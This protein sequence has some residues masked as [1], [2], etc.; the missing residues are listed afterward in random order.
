MA[1]DFDSLLAASSASALADATT[2]L[3]AGL[4][5]D[6]AAHGEDDDFSEPERQWESLVQWARQHGKELP[7][8]FPGPEREGGREHD[9]RIHE[10][11]GRWIKYTKPASCGYTVSYDDAGVPFMHN[12]V[13]L[14]YLQ[15][16]LWQNELFGDDIHLLGMWQAEPY[17][18]CIVTSQ[19]GLQGER[20]TLDELARAFIAAGFMPLPWRGIGYEG[21]LS[22]RADGF[23]FWDVHPANV[24]I[25]G[26]GLPLAVDVIVTRAPGTT[27]R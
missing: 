19:P 17:Q 13:P 1:H 16:L 25:S 20:A 18:W 3:R 24:L 22:F 12:A 23:D 5:T 14:D 27:D 4:R 2:D 7:L 10:G 26:D 9:V 21:S 11:S 8:S 6:G 15:R